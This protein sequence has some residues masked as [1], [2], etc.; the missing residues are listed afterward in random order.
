M[1]DLLPEPYHDVEA[2]LAT[3]WGLQV[4]EFSNLPGEYDANFHVHSMS[5]N[6]YVF[7]VMHSSR[8]LDLLDLQTSALAHVAAASPSLGTPR[9]V[10]SL[11]GADIVHLQGRYAWLLAWLPGVPYALALPHTPSLLRSLGAI[12]GGLTSALT[13]F[14]HPAAHRPGF[15]WDLARA[16]WILPHLGAISDD[17]RAHLVAAFMGLY[18]EVNW[19][20]LRRGCIHGD[21]NDYNVVVDVGAACLSS[22]YKEQRVSGVLDFGDMYEAPLVAELATTA[23]YGCL[24]HSQPLESLLAIVGGYHASFPLTPSE[25]KALY[26]LVLA[27]LCVSVVNS[28]LRKALDPSNPYIVISETPAWLAL[29]RF[30][31]LPP[32]AVTALVEHACN[33]GVAAACGLY[34]SPAKQV[35]NL[36]ST[37]PPLAPVIQGGLGGASNLDFSVASPHIPPPALLSRLPLKKD[38]GGGGGGGGGELLFQAQFMSESVVNALGGEGGLGVSHFGDSVYCSLASPLQNSS[39][40]LIPGEAWESISLCTSI[41]STRSTQ[42]AVFLPLAGTL[43]EIMEKEEEEEGAQGDGGGHVVTSRLTIEHSFIRAGDGGGIACVFYSQFTGLQRNAALKVGDK[44]SSGTTLGHM[45][46]VG[47]RNSSACGGGGGGGGGGVFSSANSLAN[48][49]ASLR[50]CSIQLQ[51]MRLTPL[52]HGGESLLATTPELLGF[53]E[54]A[55]IP[56]PN[57]FLGLGTLPPPSS[58]SSSFSTTTFT[59]AASSLRKACM[60]ANVR[61]SY[62]GSQGGPL[63]IVRGFGTWLWDVR[64]IPYLD[65]YN[66]VPCVGHCHPEVVSAAVTQLSLLNSNTRYLHRNILEYAEA[67]TALFPPPLSVCFFLNSAS[68]AN[69]CALRLARSATGREDVLVLDHAYHGNTNTL[70]SCSPYKFAGP[71]GSG[72]IAPGIHVAPCPDT[73]R[74]PFAG[75]PLRD[76]AELYYNAKGG[77]GEILRGCRPRAAAAVRGGEPEGLGLACFIAESM[78]S[79]AGQLF[80]PPGF[81]QRVYAGVREAGGVCIADEVQTGFGRLGGGFWWGFQAQGV[82]PDIVVLGKPAGNGFPLGVVV[83]TPAIA[84]SFDNGMEFFSTFGGNPVA[85]AVGKAVLKVLQEEGLRERAGETGAWFLGELQAL[86]KEFSI[87]GD[88]RGMGLYIGLEL[89]RHRGSREPATREASYIVNRLKER[90]VLVGTEG[91]YDNVIKIRPPLSITLPEAALALQVLKSVLQEPGAKPPSH[92]SSS[93]SPHHAAPLRG[94]AS[95]FNNPHPTSTGTDFSAVF[96]VVFAV[97]AALLTLAAVWSASSTSFR[98]WVGGGRG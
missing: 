31:P 14:S 18:R 69:E 41:F 76:Q 55:L 13:G 11:S 24:G 27:R 83:T 43:V 82:T 19:A 46:L 72:K 61:L 68:E 8:T 34:L 93:W 95:A 92:V 81:L 52:F 63:E 74:G 98:G 3:H 48:S 10:S 57:I 25:I 78:P 86:G 22:S 4:R 51:C 96:P 91:P 67:L 58:S 20:T 60:G 71:G 28:A 79:V 35:L 30:A 97:S 7:K 37:L 29:E 5:G 38:G 1:D 88:V 70:I 26:P 39:P 33:G 9:V 62:S 66:N 6:E 42:E 84:A 80:F 73:Y 21:A 2:T 32:A 16:D 75:S 64:G 54:N 53:Y 15:K 47:D 89:V 59:K 45:G 12:M 87:I 65:L 36:L 17:R 23:A 56:P 49:H 85:G 44:L 50:H 77:V 90:G 40:I 94:C